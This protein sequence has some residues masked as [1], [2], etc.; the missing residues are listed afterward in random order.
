[1]GL[2]DDLQDGW[3]FSSR[4]SVDPGGGVSSVGLASSDFWFIGTTAGDETS[5]CAPGALWRK[6]LEAHRD[7][8]FE[9]STV[10]AFNAELEDNLHAS[11]RG[12]HRRGFQWQFQDG[13]AKR[14]PSTVF[15]RAGSGNL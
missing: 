9:M 5:L 8:S 2:C 11:L 10:G 4:A 15:R 14:V 6:G 3:H 1:M 13:G 7:R 12:V